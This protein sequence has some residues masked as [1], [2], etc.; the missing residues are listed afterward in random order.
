MAKRYEDRHG[1]G[2]HGRDRARSD[3]RGYMERAGDEVR[4]W[5]G[6]DDAERRRRM[7]EQRDREHQRRY[8]S[9]RGRSEWR[10]GR[11]EWTQS[12]PDR[13]DWGR[14]DS[15]DWNRSD[16]NRSDWN[17]SDS[18]RGDWNR[19]DW[20]RGE[21]NR[22]D[23]N[24]DYRADYDRSNWN[25]SDLNRADWDRSTSR[26]PEDWR[27]AAPTDYG[28][29]RDYGQTWSS[30]DWDRDRDINREWDMNRRRDMASER[31]QRFAGT[32]WS[33][34]DGRM[35]FGP[36]TS[37]ATTTYGSSQ[38]AQSRWG[39][40]PRGYQRSDNRIHE[41]V[42]D[43]LTYSDVDAEN[44]EVTVA[45]G[46]VTLSGSVRDRW[47]KR[48]AEDVAEEVSGVRDVRNNI[49]V[50]RPERGI[51]QSDSSASDQPGTVLGI[52]P[53]AGSHITSPTGGG[54]GTTTTGGSG[55]RS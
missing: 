26:G 46:E 49:R 6:D 25:R 12:G 28:R 48:R 3:D 50:A 45:N 15:R 39:R 27:N 23:F 19:S 53:T 22:A 9:E 30:S 10:P 33:A 35:E 16:W 29:D 31:P 20:Q 44:I 42:C 7:D 54:S 41:D 11:S 37:Y 40:G 21:A 52:N 8:G 5:F 2:G 18:N 24:R 47:D 34:D 55:K 14:S 43:R 13:S 38:D 51:G 17:R 4:S 36:A 1:R 32:G